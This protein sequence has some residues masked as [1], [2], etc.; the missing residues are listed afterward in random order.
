MRRRFIKTR[1][2]LFILT[3]TF[4]FVFISL[5][6]IKC[7]KISSNDLLAECMLD[8]TPCYPDIQQSLKRYFHEI[9]QRYSMLLKYHPMIDCHHGRYLLINENVSS[10]VY[11]GTGSQL[12]WYLGLLNLA[13]QLN[14]TLIHNEWTSEHTK[15]ETNSE[16]EIYWKFS[17]W[18]ISRSAYQSCPRNSS[19]R[20]NIFKFDLIAKNTLEQHY[21]GKKSFPI[22]EHLR[23]SFDRFLRNLPNENS[24]LTFYSRQTYTII[25]SLIDVGVVF[26]TRWWLQHRKSY[27]QFNGVWSGIPVRSNYYPQDY[28]K[29]LSSNST[30]PFEQ[31]LPIDIKNTLLIGI[32]IRQGDVFQRNKQGEIIHT[33]LYRYISLAAYAPLLIS[34]INLLPNYLKENYLITIY[35]EGTPED[36]REILIEFK[37]HL[38]RSGCRVVFFL[39]GR[40]SET[41][42]RLLRDDVLIIGHSTFSMAAG[43]MNS[44][45]LKIGPYHNRARV[46]GMRNY[47]SL[48]LNKNR[49]RFNLNQFIKD[50]IQQRIIYVWN[51]KLKQQKTSIPLWLNNYS[52]DYPEEFMLL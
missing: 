20:K 42:N 16:R 29:Y 49:T 32:H 9:E 7:K 23:N 17:H 12:M 28:F 1:L 31:C 24:G 46:H 19:I 40:T 47:L 51:E 13:Y 26:E 48:T 21:Q 35:S 2:R 22:V 33:H 15:D 4:I 14:L 37:T 50:R 44:R 34:M 8:D 5:I 43:I 52:D 27:N 3:F 25:S 6:E 45:Q 30:L 39:N 41:F 38:P 18:E 36:F 11:H 10:H